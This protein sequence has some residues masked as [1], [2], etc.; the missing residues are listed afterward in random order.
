MRDTAKIKSLAEKLKSDRGNF[1]SMWQDMA[2][3][4]YPSFNN[5]NVTQESGSR[6]DTYIYNSHAL[7]AQDLLASAYHSLTVNPATKWFDLIL[8][9][10]RGLPIQATFAQKKLLES[11]RNMMLDHMRG[12]SFYEQTYLLYRS[13][14]TFSNACIFSDYNYIHKRI[15]YKVCPLSQIFIREN[16]YG[17]VDTI[18]RLYSITSRQL[19]SF[20]G[21]KNVSEKVKRMDQQDDTKSIDIIHAV[22]PSSDEDLWSA[23][24][25]KKPF[26]S[27]YLEYEDAHLLSE[28]WYDQNPYI[29][30]RDHV[31]PGEQYGR[32]LGNKLLPEVKDLYSICQSRSRGNEKLID[33]PMGIPYGALKQGRLNLNPG[34]I[35]VLNPAQSQEIRPIYT[36]SYQAIA[37]TTELINEKK[38]EISQLCLVDLIQLIKDT[39]MTATEVLTRDEY[40]MRLLSPFTDIITRNFIN[41]SNERTLW[42]MHEH[43]HL[44]EF[45]PEMQDQGI[46]VDSLSSLVRG[47]KLGQVVAYQKLLDMF[48]PFFQV[49]PMMAAR[50]NFDHISSQVASIIG[51]DVDSMKSP[52]EMKKIRQQMAQQEQQMQDQE[53]SRMEEE[54][55][56]IS[57]ETNLNQ[58]KSSQDIG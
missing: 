42:L 13:F 54:N 40:N 52:E 1:E 5:F 26:V 51:V 4:L 44:E 47:Q 25:K 41:E 23:K 32:G 20:F 34:A 2:D 11:N 45:P 21:K 35:N 7:H 8:H 37:N 55:R 57:S 15:F 39:Q 33:P 56:K 27:L 46:D 18:I 48:T 6:K 43:G 24:D 50:F 31:S 3:N 12:T 29:F 10:S 16:E 17:N 49:D 28:G 19:I 14:L 30:L 9:P 58:A 53:K 36:P 22:F 38:L